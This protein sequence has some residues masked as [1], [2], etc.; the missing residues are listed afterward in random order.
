MP[1]I[2]GVDLPN[3]KRMEIALTSVYGIGRK[4]SIDI[5]KKANVD[6]NK[7]ASEIDDNE[8]RSIREIIEKEYEVEG[9]LKNKVNASIR[10]LVEIRCY[11][12]MRHIKGLPVR[13]QKSKT[14]ARTRKGKVKT[15][16]NKKIA[17][18]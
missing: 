7:R 4:A 16:A 8:T 14:N 15:V 10:R 3:T 6:R 11:R 1:R 5:L 9:E 2:A 12:G 13:G 18:K 17:R